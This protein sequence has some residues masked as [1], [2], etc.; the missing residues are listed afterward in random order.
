MARIDLRKVTESFR[1]ETRNDVIELRESGMTN[2]EVAMELDIA[3]S[4]ASRIYSIYRKHGDTGLKYKRRGRKKNEAK[5][6]Q[7]V[8]E[9]KIIER[10][11]DGMP[12][13]CDEKRFWTKEGVKALIEEE[14]KI[15]ISLTAV[16]VY[17]K[18]WQ[19]LN[20]RSISITK[21]AKHNEILKRWLWDKYSVI[22]KSARKENAEIF[23]VN[24]FYRIT[25]P[26]ILVKRSKL[27][28]RWKVKC[29][30]MKIVGPYEK[31]AFMLSME[32]YNGYSLIEFLENFIKY[33]DKKIYLMLNI[34]KLYPMKPVKEWLVKHVDE[35]E[36]LYVP[37]K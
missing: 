21:Q 16:S 5:K 19:L 33:S 31:K 22:E 24:S 15:D 27:Y 36:V 14:L 12:E 4:T 6:M 9:R 34:H 37:Y 7:V 13:N 11:I 18:R 3:E 28:K 10:M 17:L 20:N 30:Q 1:S 32:R 2:R 25:F 35:I 26:E 23:W 29:Y 8:D